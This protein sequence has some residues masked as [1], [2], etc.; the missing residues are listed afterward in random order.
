RYRTLPST[1]SR[2]IG[3]HS[4]GG[5]GALELAMKHPDR[6]GAAYGLSSAC[7]GWGGDLSL[8]NPAWDATLSFKSFDD[9][10]ENEKLYLCQA[11]MAVAAAWSPNPAKAPF[12]ADLP[13]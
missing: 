11:Y 5:Y 7:L 8:T 9:F 3:G 1:V 13:V 6:F 4:M 10:Q 12:F 2:G